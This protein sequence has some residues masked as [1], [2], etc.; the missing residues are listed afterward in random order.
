[1]W[2]KTDCRSK[3]EYVK[4]KNFLLLSTINIWTFDSCFSTKRKLLYS[5]DCIA[6][7]RTQIYLA[8]IFP[9]LSFLPFY[10]RCP[11]TKNSWT[12]VFFNHVAQFQRIQYFWW[13]KLIINVSLF[14]GFLK[15]DLFYFSLNNFPRFLFFRFLL[16]CRVKVSK[17]YT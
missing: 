2:D 10:H 4:T 15:A 5:L 8:H 7:A 16:S 12:G 14:L 6:K 9:K 11:L 13:K 17:S 1:M 3:V